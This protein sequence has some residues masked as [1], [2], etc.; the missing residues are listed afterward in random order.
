MTIII[1]SSI[2]NKALLQ[3]ILDWGKVSHIKFQMY[4][5][6][7]NVESILK[8]KYSFIVATEISQARALKKAGYKVILIEN[9]WKGIKSV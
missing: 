3:E 9:E 6:L 1:F 5:T 7:R 4:F 8:Q 2:K